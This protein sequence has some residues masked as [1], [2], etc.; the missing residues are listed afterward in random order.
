MKLKEGLEGV[1]LKLKVKT[2]AKQNAVRGVRGDALLVSVTAA[3]EKG[4]ANQACIAL[5]AQILQL[6]KS[7]IEILA[8]ETH[9]EKVIRVRG[10]TST[11]VQER[12]AL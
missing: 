1:S 5:L 6:P 4:K 11:Q 9:P 8:G 3:P 7:N 10:L 2:K 12:L